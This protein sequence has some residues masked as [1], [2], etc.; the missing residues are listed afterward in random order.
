M[1]SPQA[2]GAVREGVQ[3]AT[4]RDPMPHELE[5]LA[6]SAGGEAFELVWHR[7]SERGWLH[8]LPHRADGLGAAHLLP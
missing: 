5:G 7:V 2:V 1:R 4:L 3:P 8:A 6:A